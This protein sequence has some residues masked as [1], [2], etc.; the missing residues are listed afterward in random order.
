MLIVI[1]IVIITISI[2]CATPPGANLPIGNTVESGRLGGARRP[3]VKPNAASYSPALRAAAW[4][5][6]GATVIAV[7]VAQGST[8]RLAIGAGRRRV[9]LRRSTAF[10][11]IPPYK[12]AYSMKLPGTAAAY[13]LAMSIFGQSI[14]AVHIGLALANLV[15]IGLIYFLG[16]QL[17]GELGGIVTAAC[18]A[19][20]SLMPHVLGTAAHATHF[21]VLFAVAGTVVLLRSAPGQS[22]I[23]IL[24]TRLS[25]W[26]RFPDETT[27]SL[28][29]LLWFVVTCLLTIGARDFDRKPFCCAICSLL[30]EQVFPA[31]LPGSSYGAPACSKSSGSGQSNTQRSTE[32]GFRLEK[33]SSFLPDI[34]SAW[35][36]RRGQ[37]G[38]LVSPD[39]SHSRLTRH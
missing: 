17:L 13:A 16:R 30:S 38:C 7:L 34:S 9:R 3:D 12:L 14:T 5:L 36:E 23:A 35:S 8:C 37:Y 2:A 24:G 18:Y 19:V 31:L 11:G 15:T 27:G 26:T 20:L 32:A 33:G 10:T 22:L 39:Q 29:R 6:F 1:I 25:F 28:F 21:V 4:V